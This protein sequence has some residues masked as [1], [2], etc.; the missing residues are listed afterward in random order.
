MMGRCFYLI[1]FSQINIGP[2]THN[3]DV[4]SICV[5]VFTFAF[6]KHPHDLKIWIFNVINVNIN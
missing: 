6:I 3:M 5:F 2:N 1:L 4:N